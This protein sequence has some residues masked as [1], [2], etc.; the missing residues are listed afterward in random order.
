M[1]LILVADDSETDR[2]L[3][4]GLLDRGLEWI[5]DYV[6]DGAAALE[7]MEVTSPDVVI[8][9]LQ[10][11]R[12]DGIQLC[13][14]SRQRFPQIPVILV[15]GQGSEQVAL[16]ALDAGAAT[17]VPKS[18]MPKT[19]A[20]TVEQVLSLVDV[21]RSKERLIQL[22]TNTRHQFHL[23]TDPELIPPL[24]DLIRETLD[25]LHFGDPSIV[26]HVNLAVEEALLNAILHGNLGLAPDEH[27]DAR[28]ALR[29]EKLEKWLHDQRKSA[30]EKRI[31]FA[32]DVTKHKVQFVI[33]DEG[34]GFD[35]SKLQEANQP[36]HLSQ[37]A[38][39]GLTLIRNFMSEVAF[40]DTGNEIRM[41]LKIE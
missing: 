10:M 16:N 39:R 1:P 21:R 23:E 35:T 4:G 9:D 28:H 11:P 2:K 40:N 34:Q 26:R 37:D 32:M 20:D 3:I 25:Q 7:M 33:R 29:E 6:D 13:K 17:Y 38:G 30:D 41:M 27:Q 19:L 18:N 12:L 14:E 36:E 22:T 24:L 8:A 15:T 31:R 5:V